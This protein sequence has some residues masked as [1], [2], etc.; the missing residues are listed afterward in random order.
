MDDL[1]LA[2]SAQL[3]RNDFKTTN[4]ITSGVDISKLIYKTTYNGSERVIDPRYIS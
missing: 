4:F 3:S 2:A 1:K